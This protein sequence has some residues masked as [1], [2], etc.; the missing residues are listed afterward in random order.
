MVSKH[1][2]KKQRHVAEQIVKNIWL[3]DVVKLLGFADPVCDGKPAVGQQG[4]KRHL[5]YQPRHRHDAPAGGFEQ[6]FI[7]VVKAWDVA[8][9]AQ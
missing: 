9:R 3:N 8:R 2:V 7:D 4:K 5:G 6:A 1:R